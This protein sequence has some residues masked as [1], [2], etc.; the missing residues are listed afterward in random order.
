MMILSLLC[1]TIAAASQTVLYPAIPDMR[2]SDIYS[3][4]V[5]GQDAWVEAVGPGGMED[6]HTLNFSAE[7]KQTFVIS[8]NEAQELRNKGPG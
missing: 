6:L 1:L 3:I 8:V 2:T 5:N 7:G 4:A